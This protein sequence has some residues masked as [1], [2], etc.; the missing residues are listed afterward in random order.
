MQYKTGLNKKLN[1]L[2]IQL[3]VILIVTPVKADV[4]NVTAST[5]YQLGDNDSKIDARRIGLEYA[6]RKAIEKVGTLVENN[7]SIKNGSITVDEIKTYSSTIL[8]TK[9]IKEQFTY[10]TD[11]LVYEVVLNASID[12]KIL[13]TRIKQTRD[14]QVLK[15]KITSLEKDNTRLL[16]KLD[17]LNIKIKN[18]GKSRSFALVKSREELFKKLE[19]NKGRAELLFQ[20]G[21]LFKIAIQQKNYIE[22]SKKK[23]D[24]IYW[25][26]IIPNNLHI[27]FD[28]PIVR[29]G[30]EGTV[31][32]KLTFH[33]KINS[34]KQYEDFCLD[35]FA[36]K[37]CTISTSNP[38]PEVAEVYRYMKSFYKVYAIIKLGTHHK[39][40]PL[41]D[42]ASSYW[43]WKYYFSSKYSYKKTANFYNINPSLLKSIDRIEA[44]FVIESEPTGFPFVKKDR[45]C[46]SKS[47]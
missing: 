47:N 31:S 35:V 41:T 28:Q 40:I 1:F 18:S 7:T 24:E 6:K 8:T 36:N 16:A 23:I 22:E 17:T 11:A 34:T 44:D 42:E 27:K 15:E 33:P 43:G 46:S 3:L 12:K 38:S 4:V 26:E 25:C 30:K 5:I 2:L 19:E 29:P 13:F 32:I 14:N 20:K 9:I 39:K 45:N 10:K 37:D 21:T